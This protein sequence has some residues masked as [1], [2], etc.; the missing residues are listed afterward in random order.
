MALTT[1]VL[2]KPLVQKE[3]RRLARQTA[4]FLLASER[5]VPPNVAP[6]VMPLAK[7]AG[8]R[9]TRKPQGAENY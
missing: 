3:P 2:A 6:R 8:M 5:G 4:G 7:E 1:D 9:S